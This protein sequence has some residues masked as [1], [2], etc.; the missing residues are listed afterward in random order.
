MGMEQMPDFVICGSGEVRKHR[1]IGA[2]LTGWETVIFQLGVEP[3]SEPE[4]EPEP[5]SLFWTAALAP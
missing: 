1:P 5:S 2:T 4:P 3:E